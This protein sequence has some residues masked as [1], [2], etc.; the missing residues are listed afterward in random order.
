[1]AGGLVLAWVLTSVF[2]HRLPRRTSDLPDAPL[3]P[4]VDIPPALANVLG[5]ACINCHSEK[6]KWPWYGYVAPVSWL[7]END[8]TLGRQHLN[9][10]RWD[11][12]GA[13][14]HRSFLTEIATV[15]ENR[16]MPLHRYVMFHSEVKLSAADSIQ[17]N[18]MDARRT[19]PSSEPRV[20]CDKVNCDGNV[21]GTSKVFTLEQT[22]TST[23]A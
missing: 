19:P 13:A 10:S 3:L 1:M 20:K 15:I 18:R 22:T 16:E 11:R 17:V 6:T 23:A 2:M 7:V 21:L 4:G 8:V 9:L 12:L 14:E 5:Q